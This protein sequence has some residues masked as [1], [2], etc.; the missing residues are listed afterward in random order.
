MADN[1]FMTTLSG[2]LNELKKRDQDKE[3]RMNGDFFTLDDK[4]LYKPEELKIIKTYRFEGDSNPDDSS[5]LYLI[6]TIDDI[7]GFLIDAYGVYSNFEPEKYNRFIR[8]IPV[9][10]REE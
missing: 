8:Q 2:V 3:F 5:I 7:T 4:R 10:H 6:Q 1:S 9:E